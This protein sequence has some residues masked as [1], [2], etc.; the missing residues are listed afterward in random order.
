L[1]VILHAFCPVKG[2]SKSLAE[3]NFRAMKS[4][5][6]RKF[7]AVTDWMEVC[8]KYSTDQVIERNYKE[9]N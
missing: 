8:S 6:E 5:G 3:G 7:C 1:G 4:F 2:P 9:L